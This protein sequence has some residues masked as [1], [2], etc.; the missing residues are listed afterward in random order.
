MIQSSEAM[1]GKVAVLMGGWSAEREVS[2][3]S[4]QAVL[5]ALQHAGVDAHGI[6]VGRDVLAVLEQGAYDRAFIVLHGRGGEDGV[7]QGA[8]EVLGLPYTGTGVAGS[9]VGMNKL[10]T[11]QLWQ[12]AGLPTPDYRVLSPGFDPVA[13]EAALGLPLM[14]KPALEGSSIGMSRVSQVTALP[15][16]FDRAAACGGPVFAERWITGQEVTAAIVD[17]EPLPLIRLET[18][19]TFYDY[20]A[21]YAATDTRYHCPCGLDP[22]LESAV[23][24]LALT[25][26]EAVSGRGW[27][28]VDLM[29]DHGGQPWLIEVNTVPG[30]TDHSLVPMA[31]R[32]A[33]LDFQALVLKILA[34]TLDSGLQ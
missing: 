25:A 32:A 18:P 2:L 15:E 13:V 30:M 7:I 5:Q 14:V 10:M 4:G 31:A 26:F 11:K 34:T 17:G 21:K 12:G 16:A 23:Q 28:R 8:L 6:D 33:G 19:R 9:A 3:R 24:A 27:G 1:L 22:A 29:I 20:Q